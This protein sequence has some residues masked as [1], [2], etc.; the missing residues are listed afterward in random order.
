MGVVG[1]PGCGGGVAFEEGGGEF[2]GGFLLWLALNTSRVGDV[3]SF[4]RLLPL[5]NH[6]PHL[7]RLNR[8]ILPLTPLILPILGCLVHLRTACVAVRHEKRRV[9]LHVRRGDVVRIGRVGGIQIERFRALRQ[10]R[11]REERRC[12]LAE[13]ELT[14]LL[15]NHLRLQLRIKLLLLHQLLPQQHN[16]LLLLIR[17]HH[18]LLQLRK[19]VH[20]AHLLHLLR[21]LHRPLHTLIKTRS[22]N[23]A[24]ARRHAKLTE[25]FYVG[26]CCGFF[27]GFLRDLVHFGGVAGVVD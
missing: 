4:E 8:K 24:L 23:T 26:V 6:L 15:L 14:F 25:A 18:Q 10:V 7:P 19:R 21:H 1:N 17:S 27:L 12:G 22:P 3:R 11:V 20:T 13:H 9:R 16:L 2:G 5:P